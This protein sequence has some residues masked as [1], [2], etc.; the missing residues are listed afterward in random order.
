MIASGLLQT[1]PD[2]LS[3]YY[4]EHYLH[5]TARVRRATLRLD[6]FVSIRAKHPGGHLITRPLVF[7]GSELVINYDTSAAGSVRVE[8]QGEQGQG[9]EGFRLDQCPEIY[10]DEIE[11]VVSWSGGA[12]VGALAGRPVRLKFVRTPISIQFDSVKLRFCLASL[13]GSRCLFTP[14]PLWPSAPRPR[15]RTPRS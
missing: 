10:G 4:I 7:S 12:N 13:A 15:R 1:A 9:I 8:V 3:I 14:T 2:E 5:T 11:R 6:G